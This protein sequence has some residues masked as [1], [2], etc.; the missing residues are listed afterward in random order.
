VNEADTNCL[1]MQQLLIRELNRLSPSLKITILT[2]Q[3]PYKQKQ[4][5]WHGIDVISFNGRNR[6]GLFRF[7]LRRKILRTLKRLH[8]ANNI[9]TLLSFWYGEC[10]FVGNQ[11]SRRYQVQHLCWVLG[12]DAMANNGYPRTLKLRNEEVMA[13]SD[14]ISDELKLNHGIHAQHLL[15]PGVAP[16]QPTVSQR[17]IDILAVGSLIA[18]KQF[19][20]LIPLLVKLRKE[21]PTIRAILIGDGPGRTKLQQL[22]AA[23]GLEQTLQ[24]A[25]ELPHDIVLQKMK[26]ASVLIH[27]STYEGMGM[28]CLEALAAGCDVISFVKPLKQEISKWHQVQDLPGME[29]I[30]LAILKT[31][32]SPRTPVIIQTTEQT[33]S[34]LLSLLT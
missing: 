4:Y 7:L 8:R 3:Y 11:F 14:F 29:K 33:A 5:T 10:A 32:A 6:G 13:L 34:Q 1:P 18:L 26:E 20:L 21:L 9:T 25:G 12:Q 31:D 28:V 23:N 27:P 17:S 15:L 16:V 22:V 2:F 19:E 30:A 24:L